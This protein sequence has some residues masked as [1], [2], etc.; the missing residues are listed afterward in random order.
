MASMDEV[1]QQLVALAQRLEAA[2]G[3]ILRQ[4]ARAESA[5][6][7][8]LAAQQAAADAQA[9]GGAETGTATGAINAGGPHE[10]R[11]LVDTRVL[12]KPDSFDGAQEKW[13]DWST[14]LKAYCTVASPLLGDVLEACEFSETPFLNIG[15][16]DG[17]REAS[18]QLYYILLMLCRGAALDLVTNAGVGE[19]AE[20]W[21]RLYRRFEPRIRSRYASDLVEILGWDFGGDVL[22]KLESFERAV[23]LY[24]RGSQEAVSDALKVG[25]LLRQ[26]PDGALRQHMILNSERLRRWVDFREE[27]IS[28][29]RV[30][31]L[32]HATPV[33]M[34]ISALQGKGGKGKGKGSKGN[35]GKHTGKCNNCGREGHWKR[36]CRQPGGGAHSAANPSSGG[37][38]SG[39]GAQQ[40]GPC[41]KCGK[42]GH[43]ARHCT[44]KGIREIGGESSAGGGSSTE[45]PITGG[46]A[47]INSIA[48][49]ELSS[50]LTERV[51]SED[52]AELRLKV[53]SGAEASVLPEELFPYHPLEPTREQDGIPVS[54]GGR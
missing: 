44:A 23:S 35:S 9:A 47:A 27:L 31:T 2:E 50:V 34:D 48:L 28:V 54:H 30:Q 33:A 43:L 20:A 39:K 12:G 41:F 18:R 52:R 53:D 1:R 37:G 32:A 10:R 3:E 36:E 19:G 49:C 11:P 14:I 26:I 16:S 24:E 6:Q 13:R 38:A 7:V 46:A 4:R 40:K 8:A 29:S 5:E 51:L 42:A 45:P 25:I 22:T 17:E 15:Q 21:R